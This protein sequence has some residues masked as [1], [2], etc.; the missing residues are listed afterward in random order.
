MEQVYQAGALFL[1]GSWT[2]RFAVD[3][4]VGCVCVKMMN[5]PS[6]PHRVGNKEPTTLFRRSCSRMDERGTGVRRPRT[7]RELGAISED[8][9]RSE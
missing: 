5:E 3:W 6:D 4:G 2:S 1:I 7:A 9:A 8:G